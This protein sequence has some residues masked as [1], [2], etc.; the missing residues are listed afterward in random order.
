[1]ISSRSC[2]PGCALMA[3]WRCRTRSPL[4]GLLRSPGTPSPKRAT[5]GLARQGSG[6]HRVPC[7]RADDPRPRGRGHRS[8][9]LPRRGDHA[10]RHELAHRSAARR[11]AVIVTR[12][13]HDCR[14]GQA[15]PSARPTRSCGSA[16]VPRTGAQR[17]TSVQVS[18]A[19][20]RDVRRFY[21]SGE[22]CRS[23]K[24]PQAPTRGAS[25]HPTRWRDR[26]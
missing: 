21:A 12:R 13:D 23:R 8:A 15:L 4:G 5:T 24:P 10:C 17:G 22:E 11:N 20:R 18:R 7:E 26:I 16:Q 3:T 1:L 14:R 6:P 19:A 2:R 25:A 9:G